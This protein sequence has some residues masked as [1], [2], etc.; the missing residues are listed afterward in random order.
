[1]VSK[2]TFTDVDDYLWKLTYKWACR[3]HPGKP[4]HCITRRYFGQFN[5]SRNNNRV[6][7]DAASGACLPRLAWTPI[8]RHRKVTGRASPDDPALAACWN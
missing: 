6:F 2:Q 5:P 4:R 1:V 7:G 8:I 3:S